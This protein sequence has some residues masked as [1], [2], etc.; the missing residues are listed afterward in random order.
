V[1]FAAHRVAE[2]S[3]AFCLKHALVCE[4]D[5]R[6][7]GAMLGYRLSNHGDTPELD[8]LCPTLRPEFD[9]AGRRP[10]SFYINTL[11]LY[12]AERKQGLGTVL[13]AAAERR[14]RET[15]S[16]CILLEVER[17]NIGA[18]RFYRR[19]G[20][21]LWPCLLGPEK[22]RGPYLVLEKVLSP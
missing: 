22:L 18:V 12:P 21:G 3:E 6:I 7:A 2:R 15:N 10:G 20:F 4:R 11:A 8:G 17:G 19:H 13:V 1:D 5:G 16:A 9:F 14:A